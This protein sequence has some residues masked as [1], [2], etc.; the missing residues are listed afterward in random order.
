MDE[1]KKFGYIDITFDSESNR[2]LN[3]IIKD[4]GLVKDFTDAFHCTIAYSKRAFIFELPGEKTNSE[5][6]D[7]KVSVKINETCKIKDFGNFKTDDGLNLHIVLDCLFCNSEF[8][9][10][11]KA[12][13]SYDYTEYIPHVTLMYNCTLPGETEGIPLK[14]FSNTIKKYIGRKLN[15]TKERKSELNK[16]WIEDTKK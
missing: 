7:N 12:G 14:Y 8:K 2:L 11:K 5:K 3:Q 13:A 1:T 6:K 4:L 15:I 16:N 9:R 10:T